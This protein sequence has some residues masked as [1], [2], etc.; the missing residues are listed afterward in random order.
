MDYSPTPLAVDQYSRYMVELF[1]NREYIAVPT[2]FQ[3]FFGEPVGM[4]KY[5]P[6]ALDVDIDIIK[7]NERI[8]A[9]IPRSGAV[10][11]HLG[12]LQREAQSER[13]S[14]FSRVFPLG[15]EESNYTA[16]RLLNRRAGENPYEGRSK[17]DRLRQLALADHNEHVRRFVRMYEVLSAQSILTGFMDAIIGTTDPDLQYDFR[18]D[19]GNTVGLGT[20]WTTV[21]ADILGD[22]DAAWL[23]VRQTGKGS[24]DMAVVGGDAMNGL[25]Q[26]QDVQA[27]ADN[28][29]FFD[30]ISIDSKMAVPP[31]FNKF[32][33]SGMTA[34]GR[35]L[36]PKGHEI[37]LFTYDDIYTNA[38][39][40]PVHY[41]PEDQV[42]FAYSGA[43]CDRYFGPSERLPVTAQDAAWY[44]EMFG[45]AMTTP[46][47]P[48]MIKGGG[49]INPG[50]FYCDAYPSNDKKNVTIRTQTAPIF[51]PIMTDA[52]FVYTGA[53]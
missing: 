14:S 19:P 39:G 34:R 1:D 27:K 31:R 36:T 48:P 37:W 4:T 23:Q 47:M 22:C 44:Q 5:S 26:N 49:K 53:A 12:S 25:L 42:L 8:G 33:E 20:P 28:R 32:I 41:M 15:E 30:I 52:F 43:R 7:G 40:N 9:L 24:I 38:A 18:R 3:A 13:H 29:R 16:S 6:N 51:A 10:T 46:P 2:G 17:W 21:T 11:R 45:M 35:I 50:M